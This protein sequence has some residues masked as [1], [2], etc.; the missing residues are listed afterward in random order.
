MR[1]LPEQPEQPEKFGII[2]QKTA[3]S[4]GL[5]AEISD[6]QNGDFGFFLV[7]PNATKKMLLWWS[8]GCVLIFVCV[9]VVREEEHRE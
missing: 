5:L 7:Q 1:F 4:S 9:R 8:F 2:R 6:F 3:E